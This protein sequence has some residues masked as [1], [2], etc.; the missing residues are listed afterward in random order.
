MKHFLKFAAFLSILISS[1]ELLAQRK[2][3]VEYDKLDNTYNYY[4]VF[5]SKGKE[6]E[7]SISKAPTVD[8][9]DVVKFRC[10]NLNE[11]VFSVKVDEG[12]FVSKEA[13]NGSMISTVASILSP[14]GFLGNFGKSMDIID[15]TPS[16]DAISSRGDNEYITMKKEVLSLNEELNGLLEFAS[17]MESATSVIYAED[18]TLDE[19]KNKFTENVKKVDLG[20]FQ[21]RNEEFTKHL[22]KLNS[23]QEDE[24]W[25]ESNLDKEIKI[26][27]EL[28]SEFSKIYEGGDSPI[29]FKRITKDLNK[30]T[31]SVERSIVISKNQN[32]HGNERNTSIFFNIQF[33]ADQKTNTESENEY[34]RVLKLTSKNENTLR[35]N[36]I[37]ELPLRGLIIPKL[38]TAVIGIKSLGGTPQ[39]SFTDISSS[40]GD[41]SVSVSQSFDNSMK[42]ALGTMISFTFS[43]KRNIVPSVGFGVSYSFKKG[44]DENL[45]LL[46]GGSLGLKSFPYLSLAYGLNFQQTKVLMS[47]YKLNTP[48]LPIDNYSDDY[49]LF[50]TKFKTGV[51]VGLNI[52]F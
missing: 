19:V 49:G 37:V 4:E 52:Q 12:T 16:L 2:W 3:V 28:Y 43:S 36:V 30:K 46:L 38:T 24:K 6:T 22:E 14:V 42:L 15:R 11:Y 31:F 47:D 18:L 33:D 25:Q 5:T 34:N 45:G 23:S 20:L 26:I 50:E 8:Y 17:E 40:W 41:D 32:S 39:Y 21:Q 9:G 48:I 44:I 10:I 35:S 7:K 29:D 1:N 13:S 51:F 27:S